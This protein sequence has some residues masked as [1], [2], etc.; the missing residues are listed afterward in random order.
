MKTIERELS[1]KMNIDVNELAV[2]TDILI[3]ERFNIYEP[4]HKFECYYIGDADEDVLNRIAEENGLNDYRE[5]LSMMD[6]E[7]EEEYSN[8]LEK[9]R[10]EYL[11]ENW[12]E[13]Y[14]DEI[15]EYLEENYYYTSG[16][17]IRVDY[18]VY[19]DISDGKIFEHV[20]ASSNWIFKY[21]DENR[22]LIVH[23]NNYDKPFFDWTDLVATE[24]NKAIEENLNIELPK[25]F[26][27][28]DFGEKIEWITDN[29][30]E[31]DLDSYNR[32]MRAE[33]IDSIIDSIEG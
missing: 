30:D 20:E 29:A 12:K 32:M 21:G 2:N 10:I 7:F 26:D 19:I 27:E 23:L 14:E 17:V 6:K 15:R 33:A 13:Y 4:I 25:D 11:R 22:K 24:S 28:M 31:N 8:K 16:D 18:S 3:R 5:L 9:T 1:E